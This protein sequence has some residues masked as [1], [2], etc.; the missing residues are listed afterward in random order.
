MQYKTL[1]ESI[2]VATDFLNAAKTL[3]VECEQNENKHSVWGSRLSGHTKRM[4]M[5]LT[6]KLA[7]L[8]QG[9]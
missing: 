4:S 9:R 7:D 1:V 5:E 2:Q 8:R 3:K 6:R